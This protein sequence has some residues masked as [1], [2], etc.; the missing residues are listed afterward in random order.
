MKEGMLL[1][2][3]GFVLLML[4]CSDLIN[5]FHAFLEVQR[6]GAG[7]LDLNRE[8]VSGGGGGGSGGGGVV[9]QF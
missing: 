1:G 9:D 2:F 8:E 6:P 5:L 7:G 4:P 3:S